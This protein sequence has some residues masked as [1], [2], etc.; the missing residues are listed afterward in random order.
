[1]KMGLGL[2]ESRQSYASDIAMKYDE[3]RNVY[4]GEM[5][6]RGGLYRVEGPDA[7]SISTQMNYF[8]EIEYQEMMRTLT[9]QKPQPFGAGISPT[10]LISG[11]QAE[12]TQ[13]QENGKPVVMIKATK[14]LRDEAGGLGVGDALSVTELSMT[15]I[16]V[17]SGNW[18]HALTGAMSL[19]VGG[20]I[21]QG[22]HKNEGQ[23]FAVMFGGILITAT[24]R[25]LLKKKL[26]LQK[27]RRIQLIMHHMR[28]HDKARDKAKSAGELLA[29]HLSSNIRSKRK[30]AENL[31]RENK[32]PQGQEIDW[33]SRAINLRNNIGH[34]RERASQLWIERVS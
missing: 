22:R 9:T 34:K 31:W 33:Q 13:Y 17:L 28:D 14:P 7:I 4:L 30:Q 24:T 11:Q 16:S 2:G 23:V 19:A 15:V 3:A 21:G 26:Q 27:N 1:M 8:L 20:A 10:V 29:G 6:S 12:V 32:S 25:A 18:M 5:F